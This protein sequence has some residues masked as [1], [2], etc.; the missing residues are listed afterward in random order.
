MTSVL[1]A[2]NEPVLARGLGAI[3]ADGGMEVA[4]I[5]TDV[6]QLT[7]RFLGCNPDVAILDM[8]VMPV[9]GVIAELRKLAPRCHLLIWPRKISDTQARELRR[10]GVRGVLQPDVTPEQ[11]VRTVNMLG[12]FPVA[13]LTPAALVKN[14]CN[15]IERQIV[16]LVGCGMKDN[17]IAAVVRS[18]IHT[19]DEQVKTLTR[20]LGVEDRYELALYGLSMAGE[21]I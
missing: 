21:A 12:S 2:T 5:C 16:S 17:E 4:D 7:E 20:R 8:A 13:E 14:V 19:V 9:L 1:I 15:P 18:D 11:L 10:L 6:V 3:L